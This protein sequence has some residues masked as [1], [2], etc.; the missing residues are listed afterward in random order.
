LIEFSPVFLSL[1]EC[2][3]IHR[4]QIGRYGGAVGIRDLGL[5]ESAVAMPQV[6]FAGEFLHADLFEMAAAY[7]FHIVKNHPFVDGNKR[8]GAMSAYVFLRLNGL[9]LQAS[10]ESFEGIV[11][12]VAEGKADKGR[13]AEFFRVNVGR[14]D[15]G[16]APRTSPPRR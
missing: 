15:G 10:N 2:L 9:D 11:R 7:L 4:D 1:A 5:L 6:G 16:T 14:S 8:A 3:E 13:V 12:A